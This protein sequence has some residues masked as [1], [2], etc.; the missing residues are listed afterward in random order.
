MQGVLN[1]SSD[2]YFTYKF[3]FLYFIILIISS[4]LSFIYFEM[5]IKNKIRNLMLKKI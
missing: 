1:F 4:H 2:I 3:F 5:K